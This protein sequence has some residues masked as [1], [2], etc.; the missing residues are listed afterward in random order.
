MRTSSS[1]T[2]TR[3]QSTTFKLTDGQVHLKP[4]CSA[5]RQDRPLQPTAPTP[6]R[7]ACARECSRHAPGSPAMITNSARRFVRH[8]RRSTIHQIHGR[9][10]SR[11]GC[12][13]QKVRGPKITLLHNGLMAL[14]R[15]LLKFIA[16]SWNPA[17]FSPRHR[18][19]LPPV[20]P[21]LSPRHRRQ[22]QRQ[23]RT[24]QWTTQYRR[25]QYRLN[26]RH[27]RRQHREHRRQHRRQHRKQHRSQRRRQ[28][29]RQH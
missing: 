18:R 26:L 4:S 11:Q 1:R 6:L 2:R 7:Q 8:R 24:T 20:L 14:R 16:R 27:H 21:C 12:T 23:H 19:L 28:Q 3:A 10:T 25:T 15:K 5:N 13:F 9:P 29:R 22:H 17:G